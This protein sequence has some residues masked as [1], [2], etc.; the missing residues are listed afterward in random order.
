MEPSKNMPQMTSPQSSENAV[1]D[2]KPRLDAG[3]TLTPVQ[4]HVPDAATAVKIKVLLGG[5]QKRI[6]A[7]TGLDQRDD[8]TGLAL[9]IAIGLASL[10][11]E[12]VLVIEGNV[13]APQL[14]RRLKL[15]ARPGFADFLAGRGDVDWMTQPA[16]APNVSVML[17]GAAGS[18]GLANATPVSLDAAFEVLSEHFRWIVVDAGNALGTPEGVALAKA[19]D[20]VV[21]GISA[22]KHSRPDVDQFVRNS[23]QLGLKVLG[24]VLIEGRR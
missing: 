12:R 9:R 8:S 3:L 6:V 2:P 22:G 4:A 10:G 18:T 17:L 15:A 11:T 5:A 23:A 19:A 14:E 20:G 13:R 1:S 16:L 24:A 7:V 21:V